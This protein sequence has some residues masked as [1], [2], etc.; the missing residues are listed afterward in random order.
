M[1][2]SVLTDAWSTKADLRPCLGSRLIVGDVLTDARQ[3][4]LPQSFVRMCEPS[5]QC[6]CY[7]LHICST[8]EPMSNSTPAF[9]RVQQ[10]GAPPDR[11]GALDLASTVQQFGCPNCSC[12]DA[13]CR[14]DIL[15]VYWRCPEAGQQLVGKVG[16]GI[17]TWQPTAFC[18]SGSFASPRATCQ[19]PLGSCLA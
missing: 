12:W 2:F 16:R 8:V 14:S 4:L 13:G 17:P 10:E 3:R 15:Q 7:E 9:R 18:Q 19:T 5:S 1:T 11:G 6:Q